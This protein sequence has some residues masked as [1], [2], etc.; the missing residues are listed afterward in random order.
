VAADG[1]APADEIAD[2]DRAV[3]RTEADDAHGPARPHRRDRAAEG[4]FNPDGVDRDVDGAGGEIRCI[5]ERRVGAELAC[6]LAAGPDGFDS[7]HTR[8]ELCRR[9]D[10]E[11]TERPAADDRNGVATSHA[12]ESQRGD[13][14]GERLDQRR[15]PLVQAVGNRNERG[16]VDGDAFGE[17]ALAIEADEAATFAEVRLAAPTGAAGVARDEREEGKSPRTPGDGPDGLVPEHERRPARP[18]VTAVRMQV[19]AADA[20]ERDLEQHLPV[21]ALRLGELLEREPVAA[22]PDQRPHGCRLF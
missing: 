9:V 7:E 19:G 12:L 15:E 21:G 17:D 20:G 8:A 16:V 18:V 14:S 1:N 6:E 10:A 2:R 5:G 13:R 11:E 22:V 3:G 4:G